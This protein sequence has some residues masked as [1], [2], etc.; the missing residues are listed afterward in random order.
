MF[1]ANNTR[2]SAFENWMDVFFFNLDCS[3]VCVLFNENCFLSGHNPLPRSLYACY[4][5][6]VLQEKKNLFVVQS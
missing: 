6:F 5:C 3:T 2:G 4:S 1:V